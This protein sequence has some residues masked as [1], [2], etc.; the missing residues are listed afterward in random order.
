MKHGSFADMASECKSLGKM[1]KKYAS[2]SRQQYRSVLHAHTEVQFY[3]RE[4]P[5]K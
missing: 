3:N 1:K 2:R 5:E 4:N